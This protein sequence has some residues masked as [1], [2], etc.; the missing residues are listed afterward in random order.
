MDFVL[1]QERS[2]FAK[3][4]IVLAQIARFGKPSAHLGRVGVLVRNDGDGR[5]GGAPVIG[6]IEGDGA[7][8]LV[9]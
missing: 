4:R 2:D 9:S 3:D 8:G 1:L 6:T 7:D 5:L